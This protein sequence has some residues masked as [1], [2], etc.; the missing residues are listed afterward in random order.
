M[1]ALWF[2]DDNPGGWD[3]R[4]GVHG[5][6]VCAKYGLHPLIPALV[7]KGD[8]INIEE[9]QYRQT[10]LM[11]ACREG[12]FKTV[13]G[14]LDLDAAINLVSRRGLSA[15]FEAISKGHLE[16]VNLILTR[17]ERE[18]DINA[19]SEVQ[20]LR[21]TRTALLLAVN[22]GHGKIVS[23]LL[24]HPKIDVNQQDSEGCTALTLAAITGQAKMVQ[25]LLNMRNIEVDAVDKYGRSALYFAADTGSTDI[26][27]ILLQNK[28]DP[29]VPSSEGYTALMQAVCQKRVE[30]AKA[31]LQCKP[32]LQCMNS[33]GCD[34]LHLASENDWPE[35][36][37]ALVKAG[38]KVNGQDADDQTPLHYAAASGH[39]E[40][41]QI[42]L[43]EGADRAI[44]N[45]LG[46]TPED[47]AAAF[48]FREVV[49]TLRGSE[50]VPADR[51]LPVW[52]LARE[53]RRD[54]LKIVIEARTLDLSA[55]TKWANHANA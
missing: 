12:H 7:Q 31:I 42:L 10:P 44:R 17:C 21:L 6:H 41:V 45:N 30:S 51:T 13:Q 40:V 32:D 52:R 53:G 49:K 55:T 34:V 39:N 23:R 2:T 4:K 27:E 16:V 19:A 26:V 11:Y 9:E 1:Q 33:H 8:D 18:I 36:V 47:F 5:L 54:L 38:A 29:D 22:L 28:A 15:L 48:G 35:V 43:E 20:G 14:L 46:R 3:V 37:R 50:D 25:G 24:E